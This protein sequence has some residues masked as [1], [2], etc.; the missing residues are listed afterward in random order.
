MQELSL[1]ELAPQGSFKVPRVCFFLL[2]LLL[3]VRLTHYF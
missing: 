2:L 1:F 3:P